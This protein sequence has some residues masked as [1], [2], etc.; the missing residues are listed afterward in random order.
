MRL[1]AVLVFISAAFTV[2]FIADA[3]AAKDP[4]TGREHEVAAPMP[5]SAICN[6]KLEPLREQEFMAA[7][8]KADEAIKAGNRAIAEEAWRQAY[9]A[10]FRGIAGDRSVRCLGD[11]ALQRYLDMRTG[12]WRLGSSVDTD[13][14]TGDFTNIYIAATDNGTQGVIEF[15]ESLPAE[16]FFGAYRAVYRIAQYSSADTGGWPR[17]AKERTLGSTCQDAL[18]PLRQYADREY[19]ATLKAEDKA[20]SRPAT[21]FE[22][23][24]AAN[25]RDAGAMTGTMY[26]LNHI[27]ESTV[28]KRQTSDSLELLNKARN[29]E[30]GQYDE[31]KKAPTSLR[32]EQRGDARLI[33]GE[34]ETLSLKL[35]DTLLTQAIRYFNWCQ[36]YSKEA[37]HRSP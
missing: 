8:K 12:L 21:Q 15:V 23:N 33:K 5:Y 9:E 18:T 7:V 2:I 36:C 17:T 20:F 1:N 26:D 30:F 28:A 35:R 29:L 34:D 22:K 14:L 27:L 4:I 3:Q 24:A 10:S 25:I 32:A 37:T 6:E 31:Q 11:Q 16:R 13:G 19:A